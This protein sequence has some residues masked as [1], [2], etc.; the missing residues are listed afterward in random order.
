MR[1]GVERGGEG[2]DVKERKRVARSEAKSGRGG[3]N[4]KERKRCGMK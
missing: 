3:G 4:Q 1:R 2:N